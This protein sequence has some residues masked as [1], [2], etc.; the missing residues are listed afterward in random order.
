VIDARAVAGRRWMHLTRRPGSLGLALLLV[1]VLAFGACGEPSRSA[2]GIV[3]ALDAP[4][5]EVTGFTL[6]TQQGETISFVVGTLEVDG[7]AF[8]ASHLAEHA[9]TLQP[10]AV[11]Y[12]VESGANVVHRMVDA[13]WAAP[14]P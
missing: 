8:P 1:A 9:V 7:A 14:S 12:R 6:R 5:G 4:A 3:L 11:A 2:A 13:P 10:I